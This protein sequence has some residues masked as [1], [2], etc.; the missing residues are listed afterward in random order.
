MLL[1]FKKEVLALPSVN[2]PPLS[3]AHGTP[4]AEEP[5]LGALTLPAYFTEV[6]SRFAERE[7]L[8]MHHEDH[9]ER[10]SYAETFEHAMGVARALVACG[11]GKD[12]RVGILMTN[13]PEWI[14]AAFGIGLTGGVAVT[15]ST[16]STQA[17]LDYLLQA[18]AITVLL[19]E[20][21]VLKRNFATML[22][23][24]APELADASPDRVICV[25]YPFLRY[26]A[27]LGAGTAGA[28]QGWSDFL[29]RGVDVSPDLVRARALS[30][31]PADTGVLFFS[32]GSTGKPKGVLS[33]HRGV[34]IQCWRWRRLFGPGPDIRCWSAN[35]FFWSGNFAMALGAAF[36]SGGSLVLQATFDPAE[37]LRL[38]QE[39]RVSLVLAWP[40]QWA[41]MVGA[42]NWESAD[43]SSLYYIDA[44]TPLGRHKTVS[45]TWREPRHAYGNTETFTLTTGFPACSPPE[46]TGE[47]H[48]EALPG[49]TI[50]IVD[51]LSGVTVA[52]GQRGEI[53]VKSPTFMLGYIGVPFD[54]TVDEQGFFRTGDG[55]WMDDR[56]RLIWEGRLNDIIKT[57]G[58]NVS[59]VEVDAVLAT[60]PGVKLNQTVGV[61]H[62]TLGEI[63]VACVVPHAGAV[64]DVE[65][66]R[67]FL[68]ATLASYKVP[69]HVLF[70]LESDMALTGSAKV[71][72]SE[73]RQLAARRI[74]PAS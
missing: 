21:Q 63:V 71:K 15:L 35:G 25:K 70:V 30:V 68:R 28:I 17:E 53:A 51:P 10:W 33:A 34:T 7:A 54:E 20:G 57:G 55:G 72:T 52:R 39:E 36:S 14:A 1:F 43:L 62:E 61:A 11:I 42:P 24:L 12:S 65:A 23:S 27:V 9:V 3:I 46:I 22:M 29:A 45:T 69:R 56:G 40:H 18:S 47:T 5:G 59:P 74:S 50:K 26:L 16:F 37:A 4:L 49:C 31:R 32:S 2:T 38:M 13:R 44:E 48:G 73:L 41:Q 58:A 64:L 67:H 66:I 60:Y 6:T 8:V 19:F